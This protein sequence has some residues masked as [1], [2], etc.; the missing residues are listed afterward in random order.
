MGNGDIQ[1]IYVV[2]SIHVYYILGYDVPACGSRVPFVYTVHVPLLF[3]IYDVVGYFLDGV[4]A[5]V[6]YTAIYTYDGDWDWPGVG[7]GV[8]IRIGCCFHP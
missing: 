2:L 3:S 1:S 6:T 7:I 4:M 8:L 5:G